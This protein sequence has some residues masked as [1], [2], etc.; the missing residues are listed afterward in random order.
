MVKFMGKKDI[1]VLKEQGLSNREVSRRTGHDRGTV[2][3]YRNEY[4]QALHQLDKPCAD[5]KAIQDTL[6]AEP[7]YNATNRKRPKYTEELVLHQSKT[8]G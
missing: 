1:I 6:F 4:Q 8:L 7:K 5:V 2:S 3:K